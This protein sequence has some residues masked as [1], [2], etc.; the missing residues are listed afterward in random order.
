MSQIHTLARLAVCALG[1]LLSGCLTFYYREPIA[2]IVV[3][4]TEAGSGK[5]LVVVLPGFGGDAETLNEHHIAEAVHKSW[6][7]ADVVLTSA[8]FAY[9]K[10]RNIIDRLDQDVIEPARREGYQKIWIAG[11]SVGAMGVLFYE[12]AHPGAAAGFILMA[13][14]LGASSLQD[15][16]RQAGGLRTWNPGPKPAAIDGDNYQREMWRVVKDWSA[17]PKRAQ[18]VWLICGTDDRML[19]GSQLLAQ[20][21]P[22]DHFIEIPGGHHWETF[23][24]A[25][26]IVAARIQDQ[27]SSP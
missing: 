22:A 25:A 7:Q 8:T 2:K 17:D 1:T 13:P 23:E 20:A 19:A 18:Q 21:L 15:E 11:A 3:P 6:P 12:Y 26:A 4:A 9:Y 27:R 16:I 14:W 5:T 10:H 24:R